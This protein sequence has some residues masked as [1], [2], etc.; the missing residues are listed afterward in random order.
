MKKWNKILVSTVLM[1]SMV[2]AAG[3][4]GNNNQQAQ[5]PANDGEGQAEKKVYVV[6]TNPTFDP[7]EYIDNEDNIVGFDMEL[8]EAIGA[9]QGF[10]VEFKSLEFDALTAEIQNGSI[11]IIASGMSI[12][13]KRQQ[14]VDFSEPYID[15]SL[16]VVV[17]VDNDEITGI[18][19]LEGK[20]V[21]A[22]IGT[23]GADQCYALEEEGIVKE[24]KILADYD[25]CMLEL[26][27]GSVDAVINDIPVTQ[28]Y[29][30]KNPGKVKMVGE[31]LVDD[32]YGFAVAKGNTELKQMIDTGLANVKESGVYD[33]LLLKYIGG[34]GAPE[35][36]PE[37]AADTD[38]PVD[39]DAPADTDAPADGDAPAGGDAP[40]EADDAPKAE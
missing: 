32:K 5:E 4:G 8:I 26:A 7:F 37:D 23:T 36:A 11:D 35:A 2:M 33:E 30:A 3:C 12:T 40:A 34:E 21:A 13:E 16:S 38:A 25:L 17:A 22:Q 18:D 28:A 27:N 29:M 20:I 19:S 39:G 6:G 31:S 1:G 15:A 10:E 9:D 14:V 24:T